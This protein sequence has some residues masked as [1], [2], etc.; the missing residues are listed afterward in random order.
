[1]RIKYVLEIDGIMHDIPQRCIKNWDN[2]KC[3][4]K[5]ADF[6]GVTRS[7][8]TQFEFVDEAYTL[9]MD[10]YFRDGFM[11][12]GI[13]HLYTIT[14]R[15][16]WEEQFNA[17]ID[18]SSL[19][20]DSNILK[21]NCLDNG[22]AAV[23][24]ANK[25]TKYELEIGNEIKP[26]NRMN[27]DRIPM[28]ENITYAFTNGDS[29][30]NSA[31]ILVNQMQGTRV[32]LGNVGE[33]ITVNRV[34]DWNDDQ[35]DNDDGYL[36]KAIKDVEVKLQYSYTYRSDSGNES[37][38][39]FGLRVLRGP[40]ESEVLYLPLGGVIK[41]SVLTDTYLTP[42]TLPAPGPQY[43]NYYAVVAG[44]VWQCQNCGHELP[45]GSYYEWRDL[46]QTPEEFFL[47][48]QQNEMSFS[49]QAGDKVVIDAAGAHGSRVLS[50]F[51]CVESRFVFSWLAKGDAIDIDVFRPETVANAILK[52][53]GGDKLNLTA[54]ISDYDP[55]L[56]NT[57][58]MAGESVR[59]MAAAKFYSSFDEFCE[60][61]ST[62][63]GYTYFIGAPI[64]SKY[65]EILNVGNTFYT[66]WSHDSSHYS[67]EVNPDC[68]T[69]VSGYGQFFYVPENESKL[70]VSWNGSDKYRNTDGYPRTDMLYR[71]D[72][73][74]YYF[75][76][77]SGE[78]PLPIPYGFDETSIYNPDQTINFVH[79]SELFSP[80]ADIKH[81]EQARDVSYS[82]DTSRIF[83]SL[84]AGYDKKDYDNMNGRYEFNF[85]NTYTTGYAV[86]DKSLTLTSKYR[87]DVYGIEFGAQKRGK[88]TT[89]ND[90]DNSVFFVLC[91][92]ADGQLIPDKS[93]TIEG[94]LT[95]AVFNGAF[96]PM[97]CI[98]V[99]AGL[100][101]M[102]APVLHL[103]FASSTGNS[104]IV[105]GGM[106]FSDPLI[107]D[108]PLMTCGRLSFSTDDATEPV[109]VNDLIEVECGGMV[110]RGYIE[111][112]EYKYGKT[113]AVKYKLIVKDIEI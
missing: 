87:A 10:L 8:S 16:E 11:A 42:A 72:G 52:R 74:L 107:L 18:F 17:P 97:A 106:R 73:R 35:E 79:R 61:M 22:L 112:I 37:G 43:S 33:E 100:I 69:F 50:T 66:P 58:I 13:L 34:I 68:V 108:S 94:S 54:K 99:N 93:T 111:E 14:D 110:Y 47:K 67:G 101:G 76:E 91:K 3:T 90:S 40:S 12:E 19:T 36:F 1:M 113:E 48:V 28:S 31:D 104:D 98:Q 59:G 84:T 5:R 23:I 27:F 38:I 83:T 4:Y 55:R 6:N 26:D 53:I 71:I 64:E 15:W 62:V 51:R 30:E 45:N 56:L 89:D 77:Y 75:E 24:K 41:N 103:E 63:F 102:Q 44:S 32:W 21:V 92:Y 39:S 9:L 49:L 80:T 81:I 60:W 25:S 95:D 29:Y 86:G 82:V 57:W 85:N 78:P 2:I 46:F 65:K 105:V 109:S 20:W 88:D 7:F 70:Y 96:S